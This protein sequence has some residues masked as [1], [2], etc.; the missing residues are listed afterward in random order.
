MNMIKRHEGEVPF[1]YKDS[2]GLWTIGVGHLIGDG[3]NLPPEYAAYA[4]N[5]AAND[6]NNNRTPA[7]TPGQ[8]NSLFAEDYSSHR[9]A[10]AKNTK[11]FDIMSSEAKAAFVDLAF[12][13]GGNWI[14]AKGFNS[15]DKSLDNKNSEGI[16]ASLTNSAW[17]KQVGNRASEIVSLASGAFARDGGVFNGPTSGYPATLHG[18]EAVIPLKNGSV[19]VSMN[20]QGLSA[21]MPD[22]PMKKGAVPITAN[23]WLPVA[24]KAGSLTG[25]DVLSDFMS[26]KSDKDN[27]RT[28]KNG[29]SA[30][31][32]NYV[33]VTIKSDILANLL[34][35]PDMDKE[36]TTDLARDFNDNIGGQLKQLVTEITAQL[37]NQMPENNNQELVQLMKDLVRGQQ[38]MISTSDSML[39]VA[40]N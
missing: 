1:P 24:I 7:L 11:N 26:D 39:Q 17:Y 33:P 9:D 18:N 20:L 40:Q 19:P 10:A 25:K 34:P 13:M 2:K 23:E 28:D 29:A 14:K 38:R 32:S 15:L 6:K 16:V 35:K 22:L 37:R 31:K 3:K 12:N 27:A 30:I 8:L 21:L 4:N 36:D 5:G